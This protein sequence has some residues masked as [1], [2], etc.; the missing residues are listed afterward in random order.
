MDN[1]RKIKHFTSDKIF[2]LKDKSKIFG[3]EL[4]VP[5]NFDESQLIEITQEEEADEIIKK[6]EEVNNE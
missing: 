1:F 5:D 3:C 2:A 6:L 4:Y